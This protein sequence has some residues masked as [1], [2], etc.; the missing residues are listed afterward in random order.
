MKKL[1]TEPPPARL[2][3]KIKTTEPLGSERIAKVAL[4]HMKRSGVDTDKYKAHSLRGAA[5]TKMLALGIP[6]HIV[7]ARGGWASEQNF[8]FHYARLHQRVEYD[9]IFLSNIHRD[10]NDDGEE[11]DG[12]R[13][14]RPR[15]PGLREAFGAFSMETSLESRNEDGRRFPRKAPNDSDAGR[16]R[17]SRREAAPSINIPRS[18]NCFVLQLRKCCGCKR[19]I[20]FEPCTQCSNCTEGKRHLR[21]DPCKPPPPPSQ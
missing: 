21:C 9:E 16:E 3:C 18:D 17:D 11:S 13:A 15:E 14:T 5:A 10:I 1:P 6:A 4:E 2:I 8:Q 20:A 12:E 7:Q 19:D